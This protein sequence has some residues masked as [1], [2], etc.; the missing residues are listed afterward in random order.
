MIKAI[1]GLRREEV[2]YYVK[3]YAKATDVQMHVLV[4][5]NG[6]NGIGCL[7]AILTSNGDIIADKKSAIVIPVPIAFYAASLFSI[8]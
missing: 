2:L 4:L 6:G 5:E 8:I 7:Y 1:E 3:L